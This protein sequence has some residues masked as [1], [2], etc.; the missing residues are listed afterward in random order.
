MRQDGAQ[1]PTSSAQL[2][3]SSGNASVQLLD[4]LSELSGLPHQLCSFALQ[5]NDNDSSRCRRALLQSLLQLQP[6][7][8]ALSLAGLSNG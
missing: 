4:K 6:T 3:P 8:F 7:S 5:T 1:P 2:A